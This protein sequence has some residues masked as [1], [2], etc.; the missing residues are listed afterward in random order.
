MQS[1]CNVKS[2]VTLA[3]STD[4]IKNINKEDKKDESEEKE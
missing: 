1:G 4:E 3:M 2:H